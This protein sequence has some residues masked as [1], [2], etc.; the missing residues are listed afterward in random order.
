MTN[1][2][3]M[4]R[5]SSVMEFYPLG[6][7]QRAGGGQY[8]FRWMADWTGMRHEGSWWDPHSEPC[9]GSPDI[10]SCYKTRQIG[11]DEAYFARWVARVFAVAKERKT[12]RGGEAMGEERQP[13]AADCGCSLLRGMSCAQPNIVC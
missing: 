1:M 12:R 6:W 9:P 5:N 10:L 2:L 13:G 4:D 8:V 11:H 7:K 3:F